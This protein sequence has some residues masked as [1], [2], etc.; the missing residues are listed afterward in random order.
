[1]AVLHRGQGAKFVTLVNRSGGSRAA[2]RQALDHLMALGWVRRPP[3]HGHPLRPEYELT[4]EGQGVARA[5]ASLDAWLARR[6]NDRRRELLLRRWPL[7]VLAAMVSGSARF[8]ELARRLPGLAE[9]ALSLALASL[10]EAGLVARSVQS[11]R[12][13]SVRYRATR[14]ARALPRSF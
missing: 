10:V 12:P 5:C 7:P 1:M 2:V 4:P 6:G 14:I 13:P 8:C 9:R 3:G 11:S